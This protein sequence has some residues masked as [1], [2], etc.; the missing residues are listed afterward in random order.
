VLETIAGLARRNLAFVISSHIPNNA[1]LYADRV[2]LLKRGRVLAVGAPGEVLNEALL[3]E[4]YEMG[5]EIVHGNG[6]G[7][8]PRAI[9]PRR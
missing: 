1:L 3:S 7:S 9:I 4:A 8:Q 2:I 6:N 5:F